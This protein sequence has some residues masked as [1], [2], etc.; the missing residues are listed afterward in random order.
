MFIFNGHLIVSVCFISQSL[1]YQIASFIPFGAWK[2]CN[3]GFSFFLAPNISE[4]WGE[5][6]S[7]QC[8]RVFTAILLS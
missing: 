3:T 7:E 4:G 5:A 1:Q 2:I 6:G 8:P